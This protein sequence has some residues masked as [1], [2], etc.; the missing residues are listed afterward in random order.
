[1]EN[2]F[3]GLGELI[4]GYCGVSASELE[5]ADHVV[6]VLSVEVK[7]LQEANRRLRQR[8]AEAELIL[9]GCQ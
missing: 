6:D 3:E 9:R 2:D 5:E 1:M 8:L 7:R 4:D